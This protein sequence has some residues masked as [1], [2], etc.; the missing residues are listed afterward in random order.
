M[1][2]FFLLTLLCTSQAIV[3]IIDS[4]CE[5]ALCQDRLMLY[6]TRMNSEIT[7]SRGRGQTEDGDIEDWFISTISHTKPYTESAGLYARAFTTAAS[8]I[9]VTGNKFYR[10]DDSTKMYLHVALD[11]DQIQ[12]ST[13]CV[14]VATNATHI[15]RECRF[16]LNYYNSAQKTQ[17]QIHTYK[18]GLIIPKTI[19]GNFVVVGN[20]ILK[21]GCDCTLNADLRYIAKMYRGLGCNAEISAG[22]SLTYGDYVCIEIIGDD[23]ITKSSEF[24]V[25][26][27]TSTYSREG[28]DDKTLD[29]RDVAIISCN[30]ANTCE[31]GRVRIILPIMNI[32]RLNFA[33][34]I[35]LNGRSRLLSSGS[36]IDEQP[37]G[38]IA[39]VPGE[40]EVEDDGTFKEE[41]QESDLKGYIKDINGSSYLVISL[42]TVLASLF[43]ML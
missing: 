29:M 40:F 21:D 39:D 25:T 28:K 1:L 24:K 20:P 31:A 12:D 4:S 7:C 9:E 36:E 33:V 43:L 32:G 30:S 2:S 11:G 16:V 15:F 6:V 42:I 3:T 19:S 8:S 26:T 23:Q 13:R 14:H 18:M 17:V 37:T 27:L 5:E 41:D 35:V 22:A 10:S 34:I 38:F